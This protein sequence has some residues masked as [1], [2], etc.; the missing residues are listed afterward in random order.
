M[1]GFYWLTMGEIAGS[2]E[3]RSQADIAFWMAAGIRAVL[4]LTTEPIASEGIAV[5]HLPIADMTAPSIEQLDD[6]RNFLEDCV[7]RGA[8]GLSG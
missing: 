2:P 6:S 7:R 4:S 1:N 5:R 3:P 8:P